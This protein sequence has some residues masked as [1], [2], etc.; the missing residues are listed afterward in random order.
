ML[1]WLLLASVGRVL[2]DHLLYELF[3]H[4]FELQVFLSVII[5]HLIGGNIF[6]RFLT[7]ILFFLL[8][9]LM[10]LLLHFDLVGALEV[11]VLL[12]LR[13]L[14]FDVL[15]FDCGQ[16]ERLRAFGRRLFYRLLNWTTG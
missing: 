1:S 3:H 12:R 11:V 13:M 9:L 7:C 4:A 8:Q 15:L 14:E 6:G 5:L 2:D 10:L 16:R